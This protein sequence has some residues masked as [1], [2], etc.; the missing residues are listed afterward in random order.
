M[1]IPKT[2][3]RTLWRADWLVE[4]GIALIALA[5]LTRETIFAVVGAGMS[6]ALASLGLLFHWQVRIMRRELHVVERL[7]KVRGFLGDGIEGDLIIRNGSRLAAQILAVMPVV[8]EGLSF[9]PS[10]SSKQLLRPDTTSTTKFEITSLRSGRFQI[11]GFLVTFIDARGLFTGEV[12]YEQGDRVDVYPGV[13]TKAP[14][15]PLRLYGGSPEISRRTPTGMD[16]AGI[17]QYAPG[18]DY[19]RVEWKAT[20]RLRTLM[21]KESH[22]ERQTTLQ[23]LID[24]GK[25]MRQQSYV[26]TRFEEALAVARLL[27][28]SAVGSRNR[29]GMWLYNETGIVKIINPAALE[30]L[31]GTSGACSD[32]PCGDQGERAYRSS[33]VCPSLSAGDSQPSRS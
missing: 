6:L 5:F 21:V 13:R 14:I 31:G 4:F 15:T 16:Y 8:E 3:V 10:S 27:T 26:G 29:I 22:P 9:K 25:T 7:S 23:I 28:E 24:A 17:R 19:H 1:R 12:N 18:D 11:S 33:S 30:E 32:L 20:A 2:S